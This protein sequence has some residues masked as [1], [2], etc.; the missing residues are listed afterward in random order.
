MKTKLFL[1]TCCCTLLALASSALYAQ[2]FE[3][4][5][6]GI[7]VIR[8]GR[9]LQ[10]PWNGGLNVLSPAMTDIDGDGDADLLVT[11]RPDLQIQ[12]YANEGNGASADFKLV[13][14]ALNDILLHESNNRIA[15][16]DLDNDS[17]YDFFA[18]QGDGR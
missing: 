3:Q 9:T 13:T 15:F 8:N 14:P 2:I 16:H 18:G 12:F 7:P 1:Q 10:F 17:D 6:N 4:E 11:G 5:I